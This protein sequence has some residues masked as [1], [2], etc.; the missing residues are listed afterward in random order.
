MFRLFSC[1]FVCL[2]Q[3]HY[4]AL[5][6]LSERPLSYGG[7]R[8]LGVFF[9]CSLTVGRSRGAVAS[10]RSKYDKLLY[11]FLGRNC[12]LA[13]PIREPSRCGWNERARWRAGRVRCREAGRAGHM[14]A[15]GSG[16]PPANSAPDLSYGHSDESSDDSGPDGRTQGDLRRCRCR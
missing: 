11:S 4:S 14:T 10:Y 16:G 12:Q 3:H 5:I 1:A 8:R 6:P 15:G 7:G 13:C 2:D 9:P